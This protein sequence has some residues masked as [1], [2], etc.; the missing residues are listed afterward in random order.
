MYSLLRLLSRKVSHCSDNATLPKK[1][2]VKASVFFYI[3]KLFNFHAPVASL[4][5]E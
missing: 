4:I 2:F 3:N 1:T 5:S